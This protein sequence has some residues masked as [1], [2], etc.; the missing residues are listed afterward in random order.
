MLSQEQANSPLL[1]L[2]AAFTAHLH[3]YPLI[4]SELFSP[5][6]ESE[7]MGWNLYPSPLSWPIRDRPPAA[8]LS[9]GAG[10]QQ[11]LTPLLYDP[12]P[13]SEPPG[14]WFLTSEDTC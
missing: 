5:S 3:L 11:A 8:P 2:A 4:S 12:G 9:P 6:S 14:I 10:S 7:L 13:V 1:P